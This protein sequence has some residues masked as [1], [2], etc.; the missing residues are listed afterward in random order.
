MAL[1][2]GHPI[3]CTNRAGKPVGVIVPVWTAGAV[4]KGYKGKGV[5][6]ENLG[7]GWEVE[8]AGKKKHKCCKDVG[9]TGGFT[10]R[11]V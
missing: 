1:P 9:K 4:V 6:F 11:S 3:P 8:Q 2:H 5:L 7:G 10:W